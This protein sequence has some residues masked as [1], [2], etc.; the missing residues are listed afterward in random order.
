[1][2]G[3]GEIGEGLGEEG[4]VFQSWVRMEEVSFFDLSSNLIQSAS[5]SKRVLGGEEGRLRQRLRSGRGDHF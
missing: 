4:G 3:L 2:E 1:M 5:W